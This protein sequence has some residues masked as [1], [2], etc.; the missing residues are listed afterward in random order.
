MQNGAFQETYHLFYTKNKG[1]KEPGMT[2]ICINSVAQ[3]LNFK[4]DFNSF[5]FSVVQPF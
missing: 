5:L 4:A 1:S 3:E 2:N